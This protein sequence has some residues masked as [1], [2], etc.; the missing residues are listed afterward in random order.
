MATM[1]W[2]APGAYCADGLF[3]NSGDSWY[4]AAMCGPWFSDGLFMLYD[5]R[6]DL[7][8]EFGEN[9]AVAWMMIDDTNYY[10]VVRVNIE[11][12]VC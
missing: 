4:Y 1:Q 2:D 10:T 12:I 9:R 5:H 8:H 7:E 3:S 6:V 11:Y